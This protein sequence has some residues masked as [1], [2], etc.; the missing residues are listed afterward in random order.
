M[1]KMV[2]VMLTALMVMAF[3]VTA[4]AGLYEQK[5]AVCHKADGTKGMSKI[6][7][8]ELLKK[9]KTA[10]EFIKGAKQTTNPFMKSVQNNDKLLKDVAAELGLK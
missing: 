6:S 2:L 8:D 10:E 1:R 5:C 9:Y 7:K 4:F 3:T